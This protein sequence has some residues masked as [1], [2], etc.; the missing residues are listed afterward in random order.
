M[1]TRRNIVYAVLI[2][3]CLRLTP[4]ADA[5]VPPPDGGYPGGNTAEGQNALLNLTSGT[6]NTA[7]GLLALGSNTESDFNTGIGAGALLLNTIGLQN[8]ATGAGAL[9][10]NGAGFNTAN[11]AFALVANTTGGGNTAIGAGALANNTTGTAN[12]AIGQGAGSNVTT[13]SGVICIGLPGQNIDGGVFFAGI[14][15]NVQPVVGTDPD[16]VTISGSG[17]LGRA[18]IS[19]RRYKHDIQ[20]MEEASEVIFA[21]KPVSFRYNKQYDATQT[22]AFG[23]I[24]ED[25]AEIAPDL[26]GRNPRGE[27]ESVRYE[28]INAMLLN[29]FLKEHRKVEQQAGE[30]QEQKAMIAELKSIVAKQEKGMETLARHVRQQDS[31][32]QKVSAQMK[33]SKAAPQMA[34]N[35]Y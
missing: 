5:V 21:L 15:N 12:I 31:K 6:F 16:H 20:P 3:G 29:E 24:A 28:Q 8:T 23:L 35:N 9:L 4:L 1:K 27:P 10:N 34:T 17:R 14:Y 19:S 2:F 22:L 13:A 7:V 11:G 32:I 26:V 18:N 25:V 30:I 33:M